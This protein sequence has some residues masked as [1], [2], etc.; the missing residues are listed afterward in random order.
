[1]DE[2]QKRLQVRDR[3]P[4]EQD[5]D[6]GYTSGP[7]LARSAA[8]GIELLG[9]V[10]QDTAGKPEGFRQSDFKLD[11]KTKQATC[12]QGKIAPT[13]Y[14]RPSKK[15][16]GYVGAEIQFKKQCEGCPVRTQCAPGKCGRT[17]KVSPYYR[18]LQQRRTEQETDSFKER[19]KRRAAVEG[20]ISEVVREHGGRRA[21]YRGLAKACLQALFVGA[22]VNLKRLSRALAAK[23][24]CTESALVAVY[25][26]SYF[27]SQ[28]SCSHFS[29][30]SWKA[31]L[32]LD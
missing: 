14:V 32:Q 17:L 10:A 11:F 7:N 9:P 26:C 20:T 27:L 5:V 23:P 24:S 4:E 13:W 2:I 28:A 8:R 19:Y 16:D 25:S 3:T 15:E 12:P 31:R 22:A 30:E 29:T 1:V 21:R 18:L 6:Q